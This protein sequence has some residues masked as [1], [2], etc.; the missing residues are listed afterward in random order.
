MTADPD[1][2]VVPLH[3]EEAAVQTLERTTGRVTVSTVTRA[4]EELVEAMLTSER[5]EIERREVRELVDAMPA[6]REEGDIIV[7]PVVEEVLVTERR[8][9]LKEEVRVRRVRTTQLH[10]ETVSLRE[11]EAVI[12]REPSDQAAGVPAGA[13]I[14]NDEGDENGQ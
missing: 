6:I 7:I 3:A 13:S 4:R 11:Q 12:R 5:V 14:P 1:E 2:V 10:Q 8:L 9:F